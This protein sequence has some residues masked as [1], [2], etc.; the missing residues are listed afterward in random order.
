MFKKLFENLSNTAYT[1]NTRAGRED[2]F[3]IKVNERDRKLKRIAIKNF[4]NNHPEY[5]IH[6]QMTDFDGYVQYLDGNFKRCK[7]IENESAIEKKYFEMLSIKEYLHT[8]YETFHKDNIPVINNLLPNF[9]GIDNYLS[10]F[11]TSF[12]FMY[13][14]AWYNEAL[15]QS[16]QNVD[17]TRRLLNEKEKVKLI[18]SKGIRV[19]QSY[20]TDL[21]QIHKMSGEIQMLV[22]SKA[23]LLTNATP[24]IEDKKWSDISEEDLIFTENYDGS[25]YDLLQQILRYKFNLSSGLHDLD[26]KRFFDLN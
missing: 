2:F 10:I 22:L 24:L 18:L 19:T 12:K 26:L 15:Y 17:I 6:G 16:E 13:A 4:L 1:L 23:L 5:L 14:S 25:E 21:E 8:T 20:F 7:L 11:K 9:P 3:G